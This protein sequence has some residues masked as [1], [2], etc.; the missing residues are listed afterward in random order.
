MSEQGRALANPGPAEVPAEVSPPE[1]RLPAKQSK[2]KQ[3]PLLVEL[4]WLIIEGAIVFRR[5]GGILARL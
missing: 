2:G 5:L 1:H 4:A 3:E